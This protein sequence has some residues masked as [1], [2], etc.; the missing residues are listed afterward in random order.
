MQLHQRTEVVQL[1]DAVLGE[2][3]LLQGVVAHERVLG[4]RFNPVS[5]QHEFLEPVEFLQTLHLPDFI[6]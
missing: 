6:V 1:P 4:K 5:V 2:A 3:Q